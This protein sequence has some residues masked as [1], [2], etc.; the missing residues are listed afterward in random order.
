LLLPVVAAMVQLQRSTGARAG[1]IC[2]MRIGEINQSEKVWTYT[3]AMHK[4]A[5]HGCERIIPLGPKSQ[6]ILRPFL[7]KLDPATYVFSPAESEADRREDAHERRKT[8]LSYGNRPGTKRK[9]R[10]KWAPGD[11]YDVAAYRRAIA[12]AAEAAFPPPDRLKR[13]KVKGKKGKRWETQVEWKTRLGPEAW[14]ELTDWRRSHSWH[15][16]QLRHTAATEIRKQFGI[17]AAQHVLGHAS[18]NM[19]ELYAEKNA[20]IARRIAAKVG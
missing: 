14:K 2:S 16:H 19:T 12:R 1:E 5:H 6:K 3:P 13:Q 4:T 9:R 18:L 11:H 17:E 10:P 20:E 15:P 8:P 7:L